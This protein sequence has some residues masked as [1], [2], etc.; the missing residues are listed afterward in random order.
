MIKWRELDHKLHGRQSRMIIRVC[1]CVCIYIYTYVYLKINI[2]IHILYICLYTHMHLQTC[3]HT[4]YCGSFPYGPSDSYLH[5][6]VCP[7]CTHALHSE[8]YAF[9]AARVSLNMLGNSW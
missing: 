7:S 1:V 5:V 8:V 4:S 9:V 2:H 6:C 3:E